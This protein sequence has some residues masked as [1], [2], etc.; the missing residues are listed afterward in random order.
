MIPNTNR[1]ML[2]SWE[3][4]D[5]KNLYKCVNNPKVGLIVG[6]KNC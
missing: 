3:E 1:L 5:A 2:R 4:S 6:K